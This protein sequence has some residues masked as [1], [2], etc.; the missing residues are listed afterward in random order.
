MLVAHHRHVIQAIHVADRLVERLALGQLLGAAVEQA[1]VR[2]GA[3][4]GLAVHF[5]DQ[6]QHAVCG[7]MLRAEIQG[8][9]AD[10]LAAF[11]SI[12]GE[13]DIGLLDAHLAGSLCACSDAARSPAAVA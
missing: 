8:V 9:V 13:G 11:A 12:A 7:R 4:H 3:D 6:A 1:D 10:F 2:I 5:Q